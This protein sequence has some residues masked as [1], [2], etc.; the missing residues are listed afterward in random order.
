MDV[1]HAIGLA[2]YLFV[3]LAIE[4]GVIVFIVWLIARAFNRSPKTPNDLARSREVASPPG[5]LALIHL[6]RAR[7]RQ[8]VVLAL[9]MIA[10][11]IGTS[12]GVL[13]FIGYLPGGALI[14]LIGF[15]LA[16][17]GAITLGL[18]FGTND[19]DFYL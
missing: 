4:I 1:L 13:Y 7:R 16:G 15:G 2:I 18:I 6:N 12:G 8:P 10:G 17:I 14:G 11:L 3:A 5:S 19:R 9:A